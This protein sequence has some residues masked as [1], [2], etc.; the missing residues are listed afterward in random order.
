MPTLKF[1]ILAGF[2]GLCLARPDAMRAEAV[3]TGTWTV[4]A[5]A[6]MERTEVAAAALDGKIYVVGG[7]AKPSWQN[8]LEFAI[9]S[10]VE[11]YDPATDSWSMTTSLPEGRHHAGI[12]ELDGF[13]YVIGGFTRSFLSIWHATS[14]VYQYNPAAREWRELAPMPTARGGLGVAV[15]Q[16]RLYAIGGYDGK[17]NVAAVEIFDSKTNTWTSVR[18]MPTPRD[19]LAV[20]AAGDRI[21]AI[22]GRPELDYHRNM[23]VVEAYDPETN[24]WQSRAGLPTAR[25]GM[26]ASV[27]GERIYVVGGE[28]EAGTFAA[29]EAYHPAT[30]QWQSMAPMP[31]A[32]HG[33]GA[34][35]VDGHL[36]TISG[37]PTPGG[38]FSRVNEVFIPPV[39]NPDTRQ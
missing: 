22:G 31:T 20:V 29:N 12:A 18:P 38:S 33:L 16:N 17:H 3:G 37:G 28:S 13:L 5:P 24:Q 9:S 6:L 1:L 11:V 15:Y 21:Y 4:A 8:I 39:E 34:A 26:A 14:N 2:L 30:D 7:F 35:V 36:Y 25:S 32:R 10:D 23:G 19:H 27:I